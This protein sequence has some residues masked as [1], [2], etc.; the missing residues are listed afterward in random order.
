MKKIL[1]LALGITMI[2]LT[3]SVG[4]AADKIEMT[5]GKAINL[6]IE[7]TGGTYKMFVDD[8]EDSELSFCD[9][10][11]MI[12][13]IKDEISDW[14]FIDFKEEIREGKTISTTDYRYQGQ[15]EEL[16]CTFKNLNL[17]KSVLL[18]NPADITGKFKLMNDKISCLK[19]D[20]LKQENKIKRLK[21]KIR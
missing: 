4:N 21:K 12:F 10:D 9:D 19:A 1:G 16:S 7:P 18:Q 13:T 3:P 6:S 15:R 11:R 5:C 8:T 20:V 2:S 17:I 14:S